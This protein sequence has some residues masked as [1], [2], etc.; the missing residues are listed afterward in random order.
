M[1]TEI[2]ITTLTERIGWEK[3]L[4]SDLA[5]VVDSTNS[6]ATSGRK[7]NSFHSLASLENIY[8][9][10]PQVSMDQIKFN[11]FLASIRQQATREVVTAI[12]DQHHLYDDT[13]DY[14][15]II[16]QKARI[17]DDAIGY[18]IAIKSLELLIATK[19]KNLIERDANLT[20]QT[21][22]VELEGAR[23]DNGHFVAKGIIYKRERAIEKAQKIL[24]TDPITVT[25]GKTW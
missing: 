25:S 7:V 22:K 19:R 24:F 9:A 16:I 12:L 13:I 18:T 14:S 20:F 11:E 5:I 6:I 3:V 17:F 21:L 23:N 10:V 8:S 1:Y 15:D 4:N 2:C